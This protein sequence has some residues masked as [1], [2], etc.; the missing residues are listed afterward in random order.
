[1]VRAKYNA[2]I[3]WTPIAHLWGRGYGLV[4]VDWKLKRL[5]SHPSQLTASSYESTNHLL[6]V[7]PDTWR[8]GPNHI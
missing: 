8:S 5:V 1:M 7:Q 6:S 4:R 2:N 3:T